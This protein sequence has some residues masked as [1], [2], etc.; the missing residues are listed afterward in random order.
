MAVCLKHFILPVNADEI[1]YTNSNGVSMTEEQYDFI[2][3]VYYDGYQDII[4]PAEF[5]RYQT[6]GYFGSTIT[7]VVLDEDDLVQME[8]PNQIMGTVHE[9][10][11]KRLQLV[12]ICGS[13]TCGIGTTL[14]WKGDPKKKS[15]DVIGALLYNNLTLVGDVTTTL[16]YSG[17]TLLYGDEYYVGGGFGTSVKLQN[18]TTNMQISQS[19]DVYGN[20]IVYASYQHATA[21]IT[22]VTSQL[23]TVGFGGYGGVF[24]FYGAAT[25]VYD[26]MGG[27]NV[28]V[29]I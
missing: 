1:Y 5:N 3:D 11:A 23:Y 28:V 21:N 19:F 22:K 9:T 18:S 14:T 26:Q 8:Q 24:H 4:T 29:N 7:K 12:K 10:T 15:W 20:G 17:G 6:Y 13:Y 27:V 16:A 25:N 2:G